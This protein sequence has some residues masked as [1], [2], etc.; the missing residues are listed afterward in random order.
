[1]PQPDGAVIYQLSTAV[2]HQRKGLGTALLKTALDWARRQGHPRLMLTTNRGVAWNEPYYRRFG[3][4]EA[5]PPTASLAHMLAHEADRGHD[6]A[7][8]VGMVLILAADGVE[9]G[10]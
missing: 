4:V 10:S 1:G 7:R 5:S 3:F 8:R 6:P 2:D 9:D